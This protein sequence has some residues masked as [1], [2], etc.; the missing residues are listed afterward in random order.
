[1]DADD[2]VL[3]FIEKRQFANW[4]SIRHLDVE[5]YEHMMDALKALAAKGLIDQD[6]QRPVGT[7]RLTP[8]GARRIQARQERLTARLRI[9][10]DSTL[11]ANA[12]HYLILEF[13]R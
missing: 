3:L 10:E 6:P 9:L 8:A 1:M 7:Y 12:T 4:Y 13:R 5:P 2:R 11:D